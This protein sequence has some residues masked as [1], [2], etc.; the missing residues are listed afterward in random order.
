M[1]EVGGEEKLGETDTVDHRRRVSLEKI[2]SEAGGPKG[3][4]AAC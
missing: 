3:E 2:T 1:V 4:E